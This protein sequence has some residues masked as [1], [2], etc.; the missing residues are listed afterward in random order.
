MYCNLRY[1]PW[2]RAFGSAGCEE[3]LVEAKTLTHKSLFKAKQAAACLN[4]IV[5][6][7]EWHT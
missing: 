6:A 3:A 1:V 2:L 7:V 5:Y 4:S